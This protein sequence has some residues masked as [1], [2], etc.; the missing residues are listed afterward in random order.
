[1][2]GAI[3]HDIYLSQDIMYIN[4]LQIVWE[5]AHLESGQLLWMPPAT[6]VTIICLVMT[7]KYKWDPKNFK[8]LFQSEQ[9]ALI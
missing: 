6:G 7:G 4:I 9:F 3:L 1:M 8:L 2:S 5:L